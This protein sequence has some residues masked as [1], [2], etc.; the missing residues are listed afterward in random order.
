MLG[1]ILGKW[2][3]DPSV[4]VGLAAL[5]GVYWLYGHGPRASL[6]ALRRQD[7][8]F[9]VIV[10]L[11][12]FAL[13]S[14]LDY[15]ADRYLFSAHM[16]QHLLLLLAIAP[17]L[18]LSVPA[19]LISELKRVVP[20][21]LQ[22]LAMQPVL[23]FVLISA[24]MWVWHLPAL[25]ETTLHNP[26]VHML[27]HISFVIT[28]VPFWWVALAPSPLTKQLPAVGRMAYVFLGGIPGI[29]LGAL[30][31][32]LP[33]VLY[34][35]YKLALEEPGLGR[36]LA[37]QFGM[38]ALGDQQLGGLIMWVPGGFVY[39]LAIVAIFLSW[40]SAAAVGAEPVPSET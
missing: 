3:F 32:F 29:I 31:T 37:T 34:P 8:L 24:D 4:V 28:A 16:V 39:L 7:W 2:T 13:E 18:A 11:T 23:V 5:G 1:E 14:P 26:W 36:R 17:L 10:A 21:G 6:P 9:G 19:A 20:Q 30:I 25:Y 40:N 12:L 22:R 15:L 35:T 33:G 27:E 38:T